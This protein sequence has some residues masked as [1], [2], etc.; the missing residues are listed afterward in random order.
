MFRSNE[1]GNYFKALC[2]P[3]KVHNDLQKEVLQGV[4]CNYLGQD[5]N[6]LAH[7]TSG[8]WNYTLL[9]HMLEMFWGIHFGQ[10]YPKSIKKRQ[11]RITQKYF[12]EFNWQ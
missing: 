2:I 7:D 10:N 12:W 1:F 6:S 11:L 9:G 8:S 3:A 4:F 5:C